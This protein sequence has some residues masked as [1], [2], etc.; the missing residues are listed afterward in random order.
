MLMLTGAA[1]VFEG[2]VNFAYAYAMSKAATH[3]LALHLAQRQEIPPSSDV[4]TILPQVIDTA[5][6]REAMPDANFDE[7]AP[8][9]KIAQMVR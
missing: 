3:S 8:P 4:I 2:P 9:E 1:A 7:W 5:A 6:N